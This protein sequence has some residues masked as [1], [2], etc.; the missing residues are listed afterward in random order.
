MPDP[1]TVARSENGP[2]HS[3][4][5][6]RS[7]LIVVTRRRSEPSDV[8]VATAGYNCGGSVLDLDVSVQYRSNADDSVWFGHD[9]EVSKSNMHFRANLRIVGCYAAG[10]E[11]HV[12]RA[13]YT[14]LDRRHD[15]IAD[16][17]LAHRVGNAFSNLH[18]AAGIV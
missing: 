12:S 9:P 18:R 13:G 4:V 14:V 17:A 16:R 3:A 6:R 5:S 2:S 15:G 1:I 8:D 11:I 10:Q 7:S